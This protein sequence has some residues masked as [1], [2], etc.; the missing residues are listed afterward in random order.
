MS[1]A[2][3]VLVLD[4]RLGTYRAVSLLWQ[5]VELVVFQ[6]THNDLLIT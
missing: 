2:T 5:R 6:F 3:S 4:H 1:G